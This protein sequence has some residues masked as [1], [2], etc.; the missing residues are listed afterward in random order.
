MRKYLYLWLALLPSLVFAEGVT[1]IG[2]FIG[3]HPKDFSNRFNAL[4]D[5]GTVVLPKVR[6]P[7]S[8]GMYSQRL[9]Y[10]ITL[11]A[12]KGEYGDTFKYIKVE[13]VGLSDT[14]NLNACL[15]SMLI[16]A[17]AIDLEINDRLLV[18]EMMRSVE[19][20]NGKS[21]YNE[22]G[23]NYVIKANTRKKT[24]SMQAEPDAPERI[25][26]ALPPD[27]ELT[28]TLIVLPCDTKDKCSD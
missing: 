11:T 27:P 22:A 9:G 3:P 10:G 13:C 2:G 20:K 15:S 1:R 4:R 18:S 7:A 21:V 16:V 6:V 17:R 12:K 24:M 8:K 23:V 19:N 26:K 5:E 25:E 28:D 14:R